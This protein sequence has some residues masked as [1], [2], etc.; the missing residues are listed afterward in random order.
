MAF[1][2]WI[3]FQMIT[4][5]INGLCF[6]IFSSLD[7]IA[8][9]IMLYTTQGIS[10]IVFII[11]FKKYLSGTNLKKRFTSS[12]WRPYLL[13]LLTGIGICM[14]HKLI[15]MLIPQ[16]GAGL[17]NQ[18]GSETFH[19]IQDSSRNPVIIIYTCLI[20]PVLEELFFRGILY[21]SIK[22]YHRTIYAVIF[23]AILFGISHM[24]LV[25]F[26]SAV[27]MGLI[28]GYVISI[29]NDL[30]LGMLIHI[31][32]NTYSLILNYF[33]KSDFIPY[34]VM[35]SSIAI[36]FLI[37]I[38]SLIFLKKYIKNQADPKLI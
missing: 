4:S 27:Y 11:F 18:I 12:G 13:C 16:I 30:R 14:S 1:L 32:N 29:T 34:H 22:R 6:S 15:F 21:N 23:S 2:I 8:R 25:Q 31:A 35:V 33:M 9:S 36:G 19:A 37:L 28:I 26:I 38:F 20:L 5:I 24:N 10:Y 17:F 7:Y 3:F